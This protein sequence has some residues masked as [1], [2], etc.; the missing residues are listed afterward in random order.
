[1]NKILKEQI[2]KIVNE[3]EIFITLQVEEKDKY[4]YAY[5]K[6]EDIELREYIRN[7]EKYEKDFLGISYLNKNNFNEI[8][9]IRLGIEESLNEYFYELTDK[10][11]F[12][13]DEDGLNKYLNALVEEHMKLYDT[14]EIQNYI[15]ELLNI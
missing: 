6:H 14:E 9:N 7:K 11:K 8:Q 1:M 3:N 2:K 4:G 13:D 10:E 12:E 15:K 5:N